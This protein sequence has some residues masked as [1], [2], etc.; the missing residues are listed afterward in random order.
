MHYMLYGM[1]LARARPML[2]DHPVPADSDRDT[3]ITHADIGTLLADLNIDSLLASLDIDA[4]LASLDGTPEPQSAPPPDTATPS[5][6]DERRAA[7]RRDLNELSG[8]IRMT[9]PG[10][11]DILMVNISEMGALIETSRRLNPGVTADLFVRLNGTRH[12][13]RAMTIRSTLHAI[14]S[15]GVVVYRTALQ[16]DKRLPLEAN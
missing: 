11:S 6:A 15:G 4:L 3:V 9:I 14:T 16:F 7:R 2:T 10:V 1:P 13:V 8:D 12:A 5:A